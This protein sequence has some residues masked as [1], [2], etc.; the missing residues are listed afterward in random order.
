MRKQF[1]IRASAALLSF[2]IGVNCSLFLDVEETPTFNA[3][4]SI[5]SSTERLTFS[6]V[7]ND[8]P[9]L[10]NKIC[11]TND[12][13]K[14]EGYE[15]WRNYDDKARKSRVTIQ[16]GGRVLAIHSDGEGRYLKE[17]SC[18][19]LYPVL[20]GK[21]KQL[22]VLQYSGGAHCCF[23][24]RIYDLQPKFRLIFDSA[25][26]PIGDGFD[27]L[28]FKDID[29]DGV[30]EFT[31]RTMTFHY[32]DDMAYVSSP[33]PSVVFE[34]NRRTRRFFP[35]S[36]K[37]SAYLLK[38]VQKDIKKIDPNDPSQ[39]WVRSLDITLRYIY[40]GKQ[41]SGWKFYDKQFGIRPGRRDRMKTKI[42][43]ALKGDALYRFIYRL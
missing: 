5:P 26:Y 12:E 28:E 24:Y 43:N 42:K 7:Q 2:C 3:Q 16:K 15:V 18:F 25:K 10:P 6:P 27:E 9:F 19:G 11:T 32:W 40:A 21:T 34:Y 13:L 22:V 23:S 36:K 39:H 1:A 4:P 29:G 37:F 41:E 38:D 17:E 35:A 14:Y 33:E 30:H 20:G 8:P 31:Q